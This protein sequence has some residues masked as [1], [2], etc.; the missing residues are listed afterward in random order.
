MEDWEN[1]AI[2]YVSLSELQLVLGD[3]PDA[4]AEARMAIQCADRIGGLF[5]KAVARRTFASALHSSGDSE[6]AGQQF[7]EAEQTL[8]SPGGGQFY[9]LLLEQG[10]NE[11]VLRRSMNAL[12]IAKR[13]HHLLAIGLDHLSLGRAHLPGTMEAAHHLD[14][15]VDYLRRA[16]R[17]DNLPLALLARGTQRDLE[18]AFRIASRSGMRL[19][20]A[21]YHLISARNS[22]KAGDFDEARDHFQKADK[23]VQ[24]TGYHRRDKELDE[25]R[26]SLS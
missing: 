22:V 13:K 5:E 1:A 11:V 23:L 10:A 20:L 21:D 9:E 3:I 4:V 12:M 19:Y 17:L 8:N 16:G 26:Q 15:A 2:S 18:E 7:R 24:E 14:Q 6:G 25:L